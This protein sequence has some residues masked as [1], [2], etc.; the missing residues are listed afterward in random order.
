MTEVVNEG[1]ELFDL[2]VERIDRE[3]VLLT[4]ENGFDLGSDG[5]EVSQRV[6]YL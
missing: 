2:A 6:R 5:T 1:R 4:Q 3:L